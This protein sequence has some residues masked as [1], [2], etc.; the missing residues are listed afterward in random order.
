MLFLSTLLWSL[1]SLKMSGGETTKLFPVKYFYIRCLRWGNSVCAVSLQYLDIN[2]EF[3][4]S[5]IGAVL[6]KHTSK[7]KEKLSYLAAVLPKVAANDDSIMSELGFSRNHET[8][9]VE[10]HC[11]S[12]MT[13]FEVMSEIQALMDLFTFLKTN[14]CTDSILFTYSSYTS[15]PV[16]LQLVERH[17]LETIFYNMFTSFSDIQSLVS[18]V[19]KNNDYYAAGVPPFQELVSDLCSDVRFIMRPSAGD[20][21]LELLNF[22]LHLIDETNYEGRKIV[23]LLKKCS[24]GVG[25]LKYEEQFYKDMF[26]GSEQFIWPNETKQVELKMEFSDKDLDFTKLL[27]ILHSE[28]DTL[29]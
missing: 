14:N 9:K 4:L 3:Q 2:G 18:E 8:G 27:F 10:Y 11:M 23:Q 17:G 5:Q 13:S 20:S 7:D 6:Y 12:K 19:H 29:T 22:I 1:A 16:L 28:V 25:L 24:R 26:P 15:L 21:A